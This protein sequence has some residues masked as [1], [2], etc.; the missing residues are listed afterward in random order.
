MIAYKAIMTVDET[1]KFLRDAAELTA[2][3]SQNWD[4]FQAICKTVLAAA[5]STRKPPNAEKV[6]DGTPDKK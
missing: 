5:V 3:N 2:S 4:I 1:A 6:A